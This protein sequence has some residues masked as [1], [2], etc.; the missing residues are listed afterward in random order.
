MRL[1]QIQQDFLTYQIQLA[2]VRALSVLALYLLA[3]KKLCFRL[4]RY[5]NGY[6]FYLIENE[7]P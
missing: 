4:E 3:E 2:Q 6:L 5:P 7:G 1:A